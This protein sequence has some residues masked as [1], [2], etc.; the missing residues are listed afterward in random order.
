MGGWNTRAG[1]GDA[2]QERSRARAIE[3]GATQ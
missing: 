2:D 1:A 3:M